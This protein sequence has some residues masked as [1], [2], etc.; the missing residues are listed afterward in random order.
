[1][2]GPAYESAFDRQI[3]E[4]EERGDFKDLPGKGKPIPG[5][6]GHYDED[7]W[8]KQ[9]I[10]RENLTG[11]L[12]PSLALR[13]EIE[14]LDMMLA[15]RNNEEAVRAYLADLNARIIKANRG[16]LDGPPVV[17]QKVDADAAVE[18]WRSRP[19]RPRD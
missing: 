14:E 13:K 7:W 3:R 19:Q 18:R 4:A 11:L 2:T 8:L 17:L 15:R 9:W 10:A 16:M 5:A 6:G 12:P 1:M